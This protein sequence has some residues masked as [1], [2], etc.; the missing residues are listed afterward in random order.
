MKAIEAFDLTNNGVKQQ[1][2]WREAR[3]NELL[4]QIEK[5]IREAAKLGKTT[6]HYTYHRDDDCL[7]RDGVWEKLRKAGYFL[8]ASTR[9]S[10]LTIKWGNL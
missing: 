3:I 7:V 1:A 5:N 6:A 9:G 4:L 8:T 10:D 2:R